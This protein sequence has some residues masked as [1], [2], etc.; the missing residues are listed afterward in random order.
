M[1]I[2]YWIF[3]DIYKYIIYGRSYFYVSILLRYN[4]L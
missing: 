3:N 2:T 1:E 4:A